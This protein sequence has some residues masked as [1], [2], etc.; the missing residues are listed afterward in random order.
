M[1]V[2]GHA[3]CAVFKKSASKELVSLEG[4]EVGWDLVVVLLV[5][6]VC[7]SSVIVF[8]VDWGPFSSHHVVSYCE[9][10][11]RRVFRVFAGWRGSR[12]QAPRSFRTG[13]LAFSQ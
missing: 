7:G 9:L 11:A 13:L 4:L 6:R 8:L 2:L 3:G 12:E 10:Y 1:E 5:G